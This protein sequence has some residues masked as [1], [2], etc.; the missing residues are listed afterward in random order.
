VLKPEAAGD[1][2]LDVRSQATG[3]RERTCD[4]ATTGDR[5]GDAF[6]SSET[7]VDLTAVPAREVAPVRT[8]YDE[9]RR[10][11]VDRGWAR[12][13]EHDDEGRIGLVAAIDEAVRDDAAGP[14][15]GA[16]DGRVMARGAR[17]ARH[18]REL[19]G[20]SNLSAWCDSAE[21]SFDEV[22]ALLDLAAFAYPDD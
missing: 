22:L 7:F 21:R 13:R 16:S 12:G 3:R 15:T 4:V 14:G 6:P 5:D 8:V 18:L 11:L 19:A 20:T 1:D 9:V 17:L 10:L 2:A